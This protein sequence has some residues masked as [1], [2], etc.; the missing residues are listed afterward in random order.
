MCRER[1]V[2]FT[3]HRQI[4]GRDGGLFSAL[5]AV[6]EDLILQ[7]YLYFCAGG[8]RGFD[9]LAAEVVLSMKQSYP[10]IQL[11]LIL[12]FCQQ[13]NRKP[14]WAPEEI[15]QHERL[16]E[17]ASQVICLEET[18]RP[19]CYYARNRRLVDLSSVCVSYQYKAKGGTAYTTAYAKEQGVRVIPC[20]G[21]EET[22]KTGGVL[23]TPPAE[24][25]QRIT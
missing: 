23:D 7:G 13:Y 19:G 3:G 22:E 12:P 18:Y 11:I 9:A 21:G 16:K 8:A 17:M 6:V 15:A 5:S 1:T 10:Q 14:L 24:K 4:R 20:S 2:C 25:N